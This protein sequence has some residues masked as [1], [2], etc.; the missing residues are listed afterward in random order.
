MKEGGRCRAQQALACPQPRAA[1]SSTLL[2]PLP[3]HTGNLEFEGPIALGTPDA[4][5]EGWA[6]RNDYY[7]RAMLD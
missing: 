6:V 2:V 5:K 3:S 7:G 4:P 1:A